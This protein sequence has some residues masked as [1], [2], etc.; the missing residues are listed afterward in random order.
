[1]EKSKVENLATLLQLTSLVGF[2]TMV[3]KIRNTRENFP[4]LTTAKF[5]MLCNV[6]KRKR[7]KT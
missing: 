2:I 3:G 4:S 7:A 5:F 1:M 6:L